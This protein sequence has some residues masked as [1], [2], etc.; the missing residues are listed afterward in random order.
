MVYLFCPPLIPTKSL[1]FNNRL[2][3]FNDF[4]LLIFRLKKNCPLLMFNIKPLF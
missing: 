1:N 4:A 3:F 2:H